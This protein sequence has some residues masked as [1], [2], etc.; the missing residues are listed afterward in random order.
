MI[1]PFLFVVPIFFLSKIAD[2][3][4][5]DASCAKAGVGKST[6]SFAN[7]GYQTH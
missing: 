1:H 3:Y 2:T 7:Q 6:S 5:I 4:K